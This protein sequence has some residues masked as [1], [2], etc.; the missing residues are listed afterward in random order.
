MKTR[1]ALSLLAF[2]FVTLNAVAAEEAAPK[3]PPAKP[4]DVTTTT[5]PGSEAFVYKKIGDVEM[6]LFVF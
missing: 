6:S 3:P 4:Q 5:I 1:L 2:S